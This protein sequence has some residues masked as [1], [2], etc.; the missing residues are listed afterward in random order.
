MNGIYR[1]IIVELTPLDKRVVISDWKNDVEPKRYV[2]ARS[3]MYTTLVGLSNTVVPNEDVF[4]MQN[5]IEGDMLGP[6][7]RNESTAS[8]IL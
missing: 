8:Q 2:I 3:V 4:G 7:V 1:K 6:L 5:V